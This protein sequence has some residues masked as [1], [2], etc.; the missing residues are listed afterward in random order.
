M[1]I[2]L[3]FFAAYTWILSSTLHL[4][5]SDELEIETALKAKGLDKEIRIADLIESHNH[6]C[7]HI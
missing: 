2:F 7:D 3:K 5:E 4:D 6:D 1:L